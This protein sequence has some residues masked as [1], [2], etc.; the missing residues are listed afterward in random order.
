MRFLAGFLLFLAAHAAL[1]QEK[2]AATSA[3]A[4]RMRQAADRLLAALPAAAR[5]KAALPFEDRDRTDWHYTPRSRNGVPLKDLDPGSRE[6]VHALLRQ[7]LSAPGYRKVVNI[8]ELEIVLRE[9][10]TFGPLRDPERYHLT[11]YGKPDSRAAWGWRFEGHHL[12]LNFTLA[13][14]RL[15]IDAPSFFGA[16]PA[17]VPRGPKKGLRALAQEEDAGDALLASLG[18]GQKS[19]AVFESRTYGD[20]VT[21]AAAKVDPLSP[22]GISAA[23]LDERQ[24]G[25]LVALIEAYARTFEPGLAE[26]R[27]ARV[28]SGGIEKI[29]F[30]W[31]GSTE[32]GR[33]HYYR[34]QGPLFLI[35]YDASQGGG[36]HIHTVWRD[37]R[38]DFGRDLHSPGDLGRD[39][40]REH[41]AWARGSAHRH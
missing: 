13:G 32:R 8:I 29:H 21:G 6:H 20:I 19:E 39:L 9:I 18:A 41:Y 35:E 11:I 3:A 15:A 37:F 7:A 24:R 27:M 40:L 31:A 36:N 14:D 30:G 10:E 17:T 1:A 5:E 38:G 34:V 25:L 16:N 33:P 12:S 23:K 26:A 28:R 4:A 22:A 2:P